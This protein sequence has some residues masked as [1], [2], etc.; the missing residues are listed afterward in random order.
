MRAMWSR[1][2]GAARRHIAVRR[3]HHCSTATRSDGQGDR[4]RRAVAGNARHRDLAAMRVNELARDPQAEA[5]A[6][7][8]AR[9]HGAFEPA[10]DSGLVLGRNADAVI[11]DAE[12]RAFAIAA[13]VDLDRRA[14]AVLR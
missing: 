4:E 2:S 12:D 8:L 3:A 9:R 6:T 7:E 10:K 13:Q 11:D 14:L 1:S 5:E